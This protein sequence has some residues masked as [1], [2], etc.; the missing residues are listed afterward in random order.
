MNSDSSKRKAPG[1][2]GTQP[3]RCP[4]VHTAHRAGSGPQRKH[5]CLARTLGHSSKTGLG[6]RK[7]V[8]ITPDKGRRAGEK[9]G[10][11]LMGSSLEQSN[12]GD[13]KSSVP[14]GSSYTW[15]ERLLVLV[16]QC[17]GPALFTDRQVVEIPRFSL[18]IWN[19]SLSTHLGT[20]S[21]RHPSF[22]LSLTLDDLSPQKASR[23]SKNTQF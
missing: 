18:A 23:A 15:Q 11:R 13:W 19:R 20:R 3:A 9:V 6:P 5:L 14:L 12:S 21:C 1:A 22:G 4:R 2:L 10:K 17:S 16:R 8:E 7:E